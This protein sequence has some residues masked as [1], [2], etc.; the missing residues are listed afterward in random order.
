M[1]DSASGTRPETTGSP[2]HFA[3]ALP[4]GVRSALGG[5]PDVRER[6]S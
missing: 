4:A 2:A 6:T 3:A 5:I 1:S